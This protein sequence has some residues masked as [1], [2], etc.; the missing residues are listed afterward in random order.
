MSKGFFALTAQNLVMYMQKC[1]REWDKEQ[2]LKYRDFN[3]F[4]IEYARPLAKEM[5]G[6]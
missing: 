6:V 2:S 4:V 1:I 3:E 5:F